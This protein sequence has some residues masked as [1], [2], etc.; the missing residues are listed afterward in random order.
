MSASDFFTAVGTL[1]AISV[2]VAGATLFI[3]RTLKNKKRIGGRD[4][5]VVGFFVILALVGVIVTSIVV[6]KIVPPSQKPGEIHTTNNSS[7]TNQGNNNVNM[8]HNNIYIVVGQ[9]LPVATATPNS[10]PVSTTSVTQNPYAQDMQT[11]QLSTSLNS[12]S[13]TG[14]QWE[15]SDITHNGGR[16]ICIF[17]KDY[18]HAYESGGTGFTTCRAQQTNFFNF[19]YEVQMDIVRGNYGGIFFRSQNS[20]LMYLFLISQN[21]ACGLYSIDNT[22]SGPNL[23]GLTGGTASQ[24]NTVS[25]QF[26]TI[27]VVARNTQIDIYINKI[28][29]ART[30]DSMYSQGGIGVVGGFN[31]DVAYTNAQVWTA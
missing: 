21:G 24:C 17:Y 31:S 16:Y 3:I 12:N 18:Y 4:L 7:Q 10:T 28:G 19:T 13:S 6:P 1:V 14:V 9:N 2:A 23:K 25:G 27:A 30:F 29:I 15:E 11:T 22:S 20:Q 5:M 26:N 8:A